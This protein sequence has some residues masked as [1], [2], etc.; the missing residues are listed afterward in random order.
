MARL[1]ELLGG[2]T[3]AHT[4]RSSC[5]QRRAAA[6]AGEALRGWP[7]AAQ[8]KCQCSGR[9]RLRHSRLGAPGNQLGCDGAPGRSCWRAGHADKSAAMPGRGSSSTTCCCPP[10]AAAHRSARCFDRGRT[11]PHCRRRWLLS[12]HLGESITTWSIAGWA[13]VGLLSHAASRRTGIQCPCLHA[14]APTT[15]AVEQ[16]LQARPDIKT[17]MRWSKVCKQ[18]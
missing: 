11:A 10:A 3:A 8:S 16:V 9:P 5:E 2:A 17:S 4:P 7:P 15:Q 13:A 1:S 14:L 18:T 12:M 6:A